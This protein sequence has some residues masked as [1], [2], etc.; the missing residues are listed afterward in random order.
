MNK[1]YLGLNENVAGALCYVLGWASGLFF[2]L[3]EPEN[4]FVRFHAMQ[5][6]IVFSMLA[7]A[8]FVLSCLPFVGFFLVGIVSAIGFVLWA[9]LIVEAY[10]GRRFKLPWAGNLAEKWLEQQDS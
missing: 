4:S 10:Q 9:V 7:V 2:V 6:T 1:T 3:M 5:S 8:G